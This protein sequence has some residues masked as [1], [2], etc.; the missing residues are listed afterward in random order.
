MLIFISMY[1]IEL[2]ASSVPETH[3]HNSNSVCILTVILK[4]SF[5]GAYI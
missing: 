5:K 4:S 1:I 3:L 2:F